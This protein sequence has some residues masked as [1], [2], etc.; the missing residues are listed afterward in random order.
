M[1]RPKSEKKKAE[2]TLQ[3]LTQNTSWLLTNELFCSKHLNYSYFELVNWF[4]STNLDGNI[5]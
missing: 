2:S 1:A 4:N 5:F 3:R